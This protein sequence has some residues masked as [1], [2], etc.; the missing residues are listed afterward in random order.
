VDLLNPLVDLLPVYGP[1]FLFVLAILETCFVTGLAVPSG[2]MTSAATVLALEGR[3]EL[4][5]V[6]AAAAAG[7]FLGDSLGFWI[8]RAWGRHVM[9]GGGRW[10]RILGARQGKVD[11]LFGRH[12]FYSVTFARLISFVRTVMPIS[13]GMSGLSYRRYLLYEVPGLG[14]WV[15]IYVSIGILANESW[16]LATQLL[17]V[18]GTLAF[19]AATVVVWTALRRSGTSRRTRRTRPSDGPTES[20]EVSSGAP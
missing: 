7:G 17:G 13:A 4:P 8:G 16:G 2:V 6:V 14:M 9:L 19:A 5:A 11:E 10:A 20:A 18:G 15:A 12:P 3:L 1:G